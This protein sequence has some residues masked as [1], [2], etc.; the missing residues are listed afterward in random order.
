V[1]ASK[2]RGPGVA[3]EAI[4]AVEEPA[5]KL[6]FRIVVLAALVLVTSTASLYGCSKDKGTNPVP[7][8]ESFDSGDLTGTPFTHK[9]DT[10]GT[11]GYRCKYH[12]GA[13]YYMTGTVIVDPMSANTSGAV[14]VGNFAFTP[15]SVTIKTGSIVTWTLAAGTHTV[16]R[17]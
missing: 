11:F 10:P 9:F 5:M 12:A 14:S 4:L 15:P 2:R 16:T 6:R 1:G 8:P 13:P 17:P 3:P 7:T